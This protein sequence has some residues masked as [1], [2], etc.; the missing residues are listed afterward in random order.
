M[1]GLRGVEK[2]CRRELTLPARLGRQDKSNGARERLSRCLH[3]QDLSLAAVRCRYNVAKRS[4]QLGRELTVDLGHLHQIAVATGHA[5]IAATH[6]HNSAAE[7][8]VRL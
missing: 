3:I 5:A 1:L 6:I 4:I 8:P 2:I 7:S